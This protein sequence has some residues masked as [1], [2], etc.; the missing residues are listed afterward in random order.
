M[1]QRRVI[2]I[3]LDGVGCGELPDADR[4]HDCG[5]NTIV[6]LATAIGGITLSNLARLGLGNIISI[7][8]VPPAERPLAS[9]GKMGERSLGKDS[10]IGHWEIAGVIT[11]QP[12]PVFPD[13]F[14][15]DLIQRFEEQIGRKV[16]GNIP[17][18][19]TEII[20]R[21]G[22]EHLRTGSPIVYTSADS[23]FQVAAH[24]DIIPV[25]ELYRI[26]TTA[27]RLLDGPYRVAR[28]IARPFAGKPNS[29]YRTP[30]RKDFSCPP[31]QPTLLDNI[32][33]AGLA[34]IGIGKIDDLFAGQG[35]TETHHTV[36][37]DDCLTIL[38]EVL[39]KPKPGLVFTNLV[40]FDMDWGHRND[41]HS[42]ARGLME[43][44]Y[45]LTDILN[46]L[47]SDDLLFITADHGCDPT[48]PSTDHSRE[49]V[50]LLVYGKLV[51]PGI[52]LGTRESFADLGTTAAEYLGV[53]P[54]PAGVSFWGVIAR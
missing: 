47:Q 51:K 10:T 54:T 43:F 34:V 53:K 33:S 27:R 42:F 11:D 28:V 15:W 17:A 48:T 21:L 30:E 18:S 25:P 29:F 1:F 12:F 45:A 14:P 6:N 44:D 38:K 49:Y 2:I 16:L 50:P 46:R 4:F 32:K 37:N 26:C 36:K 52:D 24:V 5:S 23:V 3:V 22:E 20:N 41:L 39:D 7:A 13:G 31:P 35:L 19:G 40:Q 8:G 9:F